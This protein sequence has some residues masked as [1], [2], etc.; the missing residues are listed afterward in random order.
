MRKSGENYGKIVFCTKFSSNIEKFGE[1]F[2][3]KTVL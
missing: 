3:K 2:E 1:K